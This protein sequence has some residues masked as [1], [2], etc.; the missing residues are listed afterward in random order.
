MPDVFLS[1]NTSPLQLVWRIVDLG[2]G[3]Q[4]GPRVVDGPYVSLIYGLVVGSFGTR[5]SSAISCGSGGGR[6]GSVSFPGCLSFGVDMGGCRVQCSGS[7]IAV[8]LGG[9]SS[10]VLFLMP[11][12]F[13]KSVISLDHF[14]DTYK[15]I[16]TP[17]AWRSS[18]SRPCRDD[19]CDDSCDDL[20]DVGE[21]GDS[22]SSL[23]HAGVK[24]SSFMP[25]SAT[26]IATP[27][28]FEFIQI[29]PAR[30]DCLDHGV[31]GGGGAT[32]EG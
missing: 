9:C 29:R 30:I 28:C 16:C 8:A 4:D 10:Q 2:A 27:S 24:H 3:A 21:L 14:N 6:L 23:S 15:V 31:L 26:K 19:F 25:D 22:N 18:V 1:S 17:M 7:A 12:P 5:T 20:C 13:S 11:L 32:K